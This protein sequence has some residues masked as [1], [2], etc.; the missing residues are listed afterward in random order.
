[1]SARATIP[2]VWLHAEALIRR[3]SGSDDMEDGFFCGRFLTRPW[4]L[5]RALAYLVRK[6][7]D[8]DSFHNRYRRV[9]RHS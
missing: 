1:M 4:G 9:P 7:E 6:G 2:T 3:R 5:S 8:D